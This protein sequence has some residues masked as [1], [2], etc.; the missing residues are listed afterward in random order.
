MGRMRRLL[1][2]ASRL[3]EKPPVQHRELLELVTVLKTQL[4]SAN[5]A[6]AQVVG[7]LLIIERQLAGLAAA[8]SDAI[9]HAAGLDAYGIEVDPPSGGGVGASPTC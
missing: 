7:S 5:A 8:V 1:K 9:T 3:S 6:R 4:D 2:P